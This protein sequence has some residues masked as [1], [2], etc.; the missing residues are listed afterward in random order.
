M[1]PQLLIVLVMA[2]LLWLASIDGKPR[3]DDVEIQGAGVSVHH[4][5]AD[6]GAAGPAQP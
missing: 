5:I 2:L 4:E 3:G 6:H 1:V